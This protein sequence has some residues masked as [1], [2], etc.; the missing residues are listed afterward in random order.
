LNTTGI[1]DITAGRSQDSGSIRLRASQPR[2]RGT[3]GV[4]REIVIE[5]KN[6]HNFFELVGQNKQIHK[7]VSFSTQKSIDNY[8]WIIISTTY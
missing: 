8:Y 6:E 2:F 4:P 7:K 3:L 5:K 1:N